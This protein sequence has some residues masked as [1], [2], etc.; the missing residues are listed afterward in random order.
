MSAPTA[1]G[2][3]RLVLDRPLAVL[4]EAGE[5]DHDPLALEL[6]QLA[7]LGGLGRRHRAGP[8]ERERRASVS[9]S[10]IPAT[11]TTLSRLV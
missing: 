8:I 3:A 4:A 2:L 10:E 1:A 5:R 9:S 11:V 6:E 7:E